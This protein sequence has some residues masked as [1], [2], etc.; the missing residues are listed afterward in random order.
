M[1]RN[2]AFMYAI[3]LTQGMVFYGPVATLYR[4]AQGVSVFE[5]TLIESISMLLCILLEIPWGM[6]ADRIGYKKTMVVSN[7]VYFLS[8]LVFWQATGFAGFLAERVLL[9][10][11]IAGLSGV[12]V[13]LLY[14]SSPEQNRQRVLG[15]YNGLGMAGLLAA[16]VA[17]TLLPLQH[18]RLLGGLTAVSYGIAALLTL[19]LAETAAP[20]SREITLRHTVRLLGQTLRNKSLLCFLLAVALLSETHQTITVF[21]NQLQYT[22][23]GMTEAGIGYAYMAATA[24]GLA[25]GYS[26]R[27]TQRAGRKRAGICLFLLPLC[28]CLALACCPFPLPSVAGILTLRLCDSLFQ[29]FQ[30][31]IQNELLRTPYRATA[32]SL[33]AMLTDGIAIGTNLAYGA[34]AQRSLPLAFGFGALLCLTGLGLFLA[35]YRRMQAAL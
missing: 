15:I 10:V 24:L 11:A 28:A 3:A 23:S 2:I 33:N 9:S 27:F 16:S 12:D 25:S 30:T 21:L 5:I 35:W 1:K 26:A 29:P 14:L 34:L 20:G 8:K 19:G 17:Y 13:N 31:K 4:Q 32:L 6:I 18:Y 22:R 7:L